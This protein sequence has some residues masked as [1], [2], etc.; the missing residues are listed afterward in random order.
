M[1]SVR[2]ELP[3]DI[4]VEMKWRCSPGLCGHDC[5]SQWACTALFSRDLENTQ[6]SLTTVSNF[7]LFTT[8]PSSERENVILPIPGGF[9]LSADHV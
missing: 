7:E 5:C 6:P 1:V 9:L 4:V 2:N 8:K 3:V